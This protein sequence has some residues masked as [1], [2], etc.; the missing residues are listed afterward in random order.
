MFLSS[1]PTLTDVFNTETSRTQLTLSVYLVGFAIGQLVYGPVSDCY[2]RK[3]PLLVGTALI[4]GAFVGVCA[5][6][7]AFMN[8]SFIMAGSA[9]TNGLLLVVAILLML[10]WKIEGYL[11]ADF[12]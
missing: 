8:W 2:G 11:G 12:V 1:L 9:S 5:F 7:G 10:A 4:I 6:F 3:T